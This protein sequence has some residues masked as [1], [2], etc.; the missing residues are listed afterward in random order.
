[1]ACLFFL[2]ELTENI[3]EICIH[4]IVQEKNLHVDFK[5]WVCTALSMHFPLSE[6][7]FFF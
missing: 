1:M 6:L 3:K 7:Y 4:N 5:M 2:D